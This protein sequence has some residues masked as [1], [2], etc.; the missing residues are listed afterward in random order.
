ME[1]FIKA[2]LEEKATAT[3]KEK[4]G[5][6][7][8]KAIAAL[9]EAYTL[10]PEQK[11]AF[12]I[13]NY[14]SK[15]VL[16]DNAN[17]VLIKE[18]EVQKTNSGNTIDALNNQIDFLTGEVKRLDVELVE[19]QGIAEEALKGY[20]K[21]ADQAPVALEID[22]QSGTAKII[23]GVNFNGKDYTAAE[24]AENVEVVEELLAIGSGAITVVED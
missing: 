4:M 12:H 21:V 20:N 18:L 16:M 1:D 23:F 24:L 2:I 8:D 13:E 19:A 5:A 10:S 15:I 3:N 7:V 6:L 9:S 22:V 14:K 11:V 17:E